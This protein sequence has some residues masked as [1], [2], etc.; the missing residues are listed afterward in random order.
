MAFFRKKEIEKDDA[1]RKKENMPKISLKKKRRIGF[2]H[3]TKKQQNHVLTTEHIPPQIPVTSPQNEPRTTPNQENLPQQRENIDLFLEDIT[4]N[5]EVKKEPPLNTE[6]TQT[7]E[8]STTKRKVFSQRDMKGKLIYLEDTGEQLGTIFDAMYDSDKNLIGYKIKDSKSETV[9]SFPLE[10]FDEDKNGLIFIPS[11]YTK[12]MKT[13]EKFEFNDRITPELTWLIK[14][15]MV[16]TEEL[17]SIFVKHDD[18]I[19]NHIKEAVALRELL[20]SRL[21]ILEKERLI[22]KENLMDLTEKRLIKDIDRRQFS[23]IVMDHRRKVNIVDIN[24]KKCKELL[25]RLQHTSFGLL[26][27]SIASTVETEEHR[28]PHDAAEN[29]RKEHMPS[30]YTREDPYKEKY[31]ELKDRYEKLQEG[32]NELKIAV[33]KLLNKNEL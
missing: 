30:D 6:T 15:N 33:E 12:G 29:W 26:S 31:L 19:A 3:K 32:Y 21:K 20:N 7:Q 10:Q 13:I 25:D 28:E 22:L 4:A 18:K 23:E 2:G 5:D 1:A 27:Q 17:Y 24:I 8:W 9:L 14:D 16:S 11:W